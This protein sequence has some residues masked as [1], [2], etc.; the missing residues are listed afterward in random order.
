MDLGAPG[1]DPGPV[2][3][4]VTLDREKFEAEEKILQSREEAELASGDQHAAAD[5]GRA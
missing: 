5:A 1:P 2:L 4:Q 3:T